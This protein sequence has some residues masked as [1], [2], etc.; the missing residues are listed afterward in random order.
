MCAAS[1]RAP[2]D[3]TTRIRVGSTSD[4]QEKE[5]ISEEEKK[6][7]R[8]KGIKG[9]GKESNNCERSA[10]GIKRNNAKTGE[11]EM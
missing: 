11:R 3:A 6:R 7:Q 10:G 2:D 9:K 4:I 5:A 1:Q 8:K